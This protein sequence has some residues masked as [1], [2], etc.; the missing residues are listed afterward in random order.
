MFISGIRYLMFAGVS[1]GDDTNYFFIAFRMPLSLVA[2][3]LLTVMFIRQE[4]I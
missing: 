4:V 2:I 1:V 3:F